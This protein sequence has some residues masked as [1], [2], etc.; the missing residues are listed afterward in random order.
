MRLLEGRELQRRHWSA[1]SLG[2]VKHLGLSRAHGQVS[3]FATLRLA[4]WDGSDNNESNYMNNHDESLL[5]DHDNNNQLHDDMKQ[6]MNMEMN[7]SSSLP[8][9]SNNNDSAQA[10]SSSS[11]ANSTA[12]NTTQLTPFGQHGSLR[13]STATAMSMTQFRSQTSAQQQQQQRDQAELPAVRNTTPKIKNFASPKKNHSKR[14][15]A[16]TT[17]SSTSMD[18]NNFAHPFPPPLVPSNHTTTQS[19]SKSGVEKSKPI[20][21]NY[22]SNNHPHHY[23][24]EIFKSS[25]VPNDSNPVWGDNTTST[26]NTN[27]NNNNNTTDSNNTNQSNFQIPLHKDDLLPTHQTDGAKI[28]LQIRLDEEMAPT[29][30]LLVNGALSS[31]VNVASVATSVVGMGRQTKEVSNMGR[32]ILGLGSDRLIG[33]GVVDLMPLLVGMWEEEW[34]GGSSGGGVEEEKEVSLDV[35]GRIPLNARRM[36]RRVERMGMLDVWVPLI[37]P[38]DEVDGKKKGGDGDG[39]NAGKVHLLISYQPNGMTPKRDDV[40]A[41]ESFSRR[42]FDQVMNGDGSIGRSSNTIIHRS[43]VVASFIQFFQHYHPSS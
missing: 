13:S 15:Q 5:H 16:P 42:P 23:A 26:A 19:S 1:L 2:P 38:S 32:E 41:L 21:K 25:T 18:S 6:P 3:S 7:E 39:T 12:G 9:K 37:H 24:K 28:K 10:A 35:Y 17:A 33:R 8:I 29:E 4:F 11:T 22:D 36:R 14:S 43:T 27:S 31:A 34:D 20:H 40:V 30:S